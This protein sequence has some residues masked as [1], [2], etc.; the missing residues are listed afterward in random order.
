MLGCAVT[1]M[2]MVATAQSVVTG[3][4]SLAGPD[5]RGEPP[6]RNEAFVP[7]ARNAL[8]P[9]QALNPLPEVVIVLEGGE[10]PEN[11]RK[12]PSS[13]TRYVIIGESF[14]FELLPIVAGAK[15]E[16]KNEGKRSPRLYS[17]THP[18]VVPSDP[19]NPKGVRPL[20]SIE[21]PL[22]RIEIRDRETPHLRGSVV[23]FP[24]AL[25]SS[26]KNSGRFSIAGVP[27]GKWTAKVW[28]RDGWV[29]MKAVTIEVPQKRGA[30]ARIQLPAL[31]ET[32]KPGGGE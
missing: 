3:V 12:A 31:L 24:H 20:E 18:D 7:R 15:V 22:Q 21:A 27:D 1:A 29:K 10:V 8:K 4:V 17:P 2:P 13:L 26:V 11:A 28:Y 16:V 30:T 23:A 14:D 25:F 6:V 19:I 5:K 32:I 9:T